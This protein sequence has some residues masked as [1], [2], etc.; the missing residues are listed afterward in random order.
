[1]AGYQT[2]LGQAGVHEMLKPATPGLAEL[3]VLCDYKVHR[4][5]QILVQRFHRGKG[6]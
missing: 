6:Q 4:I 3:P 1:M 2:S 5:K